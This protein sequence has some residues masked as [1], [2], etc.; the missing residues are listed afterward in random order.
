M[1]NNGIK[2][3]LILGGAL[4]LTYLVLYMVSPMALLGGAPWLAF[5]IEIIIVSMAIKAERR[6][7]GGI[8]SFKEGLST[9]FLTFVVGVLIS[10]IFQYIL[11]NFIAPDFAEQ[12]SEAVMDAMDKF[13][14]YLQEDQLSQL[15]QLE[16]TLE[17]NKGVQYTFASLMK[18]YLFKLI[19]PGF[20]IAALSALILKKEPKTFA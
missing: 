7:R 14:D 9:G 8:I 3:G 16:E 1:Q 18:G 4:A 2:Y 11:Y 19:I 15:D 5:I 10:T 13:S 12:T 17:K 20:L 6:A